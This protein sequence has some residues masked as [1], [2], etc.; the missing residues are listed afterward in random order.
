MDSGARSALPYRGGV[1]GADQRLDVQRRINRGDLV[2]LETTW[3]TVRGGFEAAAEEGRR[4]I[5]SIAEYQAMID[6][7]IARDSG[8]TPIPLLGGAR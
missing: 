8:V 5:R 1:F 6:L 2:A 4:N 3:L 7:K